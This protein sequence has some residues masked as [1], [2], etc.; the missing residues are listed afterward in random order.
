MA[1]RAR[2]GVWEWQVRLLPHATNVNFDV[3]VD[4]HVHVDVHVFAFPRLTLENTTM[5]LHRR[6]IP[7][8]AWSA[9][10][11]GGERGAQMLD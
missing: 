4:V 6:A 11:S 3:D 9:T 5:T 10:Q 1:A 7:Q 8:L 2:R